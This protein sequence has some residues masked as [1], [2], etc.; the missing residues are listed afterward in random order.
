MLR[1]LYPTRV[2][3]PHARAGRFWLTVVRVVKGD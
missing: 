3:G 2:G 1:A